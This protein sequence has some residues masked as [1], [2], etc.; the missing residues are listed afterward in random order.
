ML[1]FFQARTGFLVVDVRRSATRS[2][3][4]ALWQCESVTQMY[5]GCVAQISL[6]QT[7][8]LVKTSVFREDLKRCAVS[9][10][11]M[12]RDDSW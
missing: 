7:K 11:S 2:S 4:R 10:L 3:V 6:T 5:V 12:G 1:L 9:F 8:S